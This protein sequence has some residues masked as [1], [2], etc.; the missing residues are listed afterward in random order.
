MADLTPDTPLAQTF[1]SDVV[2]ISFAPA[3][4]S[5]V[6]RHFLLTAIAN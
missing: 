2:G 4:G 5:A 3:N 6:R 1:R